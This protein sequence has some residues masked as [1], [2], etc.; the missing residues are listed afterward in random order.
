MASG[1]VTV[2]GTAVSK[3]IEILGEL[4]VSLDPDGGQETARRR[5]IYS[6]MHL[7]LVE[8]HANCRAASFAYVESA[9][10]SL[11]DNWK[12]TLTLL[13]MGTPSTR[14]WDDIEEEE[15]LPVAPVDQFAYRAAGAGV[16]AR[17]GWSA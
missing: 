6:S 1:D 7:E 12:E 10:Q 15:K 8:A 9:F 13:R 4:L 2:R 17:I 14:D 11:L 5:R 3:C 16:A